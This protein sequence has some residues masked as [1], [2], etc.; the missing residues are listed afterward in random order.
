LIRVL[1]HS[2]SPI[3]LFSRLRQKCILGMIA[4]FEPEDSG[5]LRALWLDDR[6]GLSPQ[7]ELLMIDAGIFHVIAISGF[8][9]A[10][11]LAIAF[12]LLK[13]WVSYR[14]ALILLGLLLLAYFLLLEGRSA[15]TRSFLTFLI[16]AVATWRYEKVDWPNVLSLSAFL[17]LIFNP[18]DL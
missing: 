8:H 2:Y 15:I 11:V 1:Q 4:T 3:S 17:Q 7:M 13:R 6:T 9:I 18:L 5:L 14:K 12:F 10:I 16:F